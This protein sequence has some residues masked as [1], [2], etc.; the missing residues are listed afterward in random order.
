MLIVDFPGGVV[1]FAKVLLLNDGGVDF[2]DGKFYLPT[3]VQ[4]DEGDEYFGEVEEE[5]G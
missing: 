3:L 4:R 2:L 5:D 1:Y